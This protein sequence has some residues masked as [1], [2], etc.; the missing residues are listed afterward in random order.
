MNLQQNIFCIKDEIYRYMYETY[1]PVFTV[2]KIWKLAFFSFGEL[3]FTLHYF[4]KCH[5]KHKTVL[6]NNT[7]NYY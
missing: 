4:M 1:I 5:F 6:F 3:L 7:K 2:L